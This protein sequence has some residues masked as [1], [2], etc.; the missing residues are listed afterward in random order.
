MGDLLLKQRP[1]TVKHWQSLE[2]LSRRGWP[3]VHPQYL[4][5]NRQILSFKPPDWRERGN[6]ILPHSTYNSSNYCQINKSRDYC[7]LAPYYRNA[8]PPP[9]NPNKDRLLM[10]DPT[11][12]R[13]TSR[14]AEVHPCQCRSR[15][16]DD[17]RP[18]FVEMSS[19][20]EED[21]NG[22]K[23]GRRHKNK[24]NYDKHSKKYRSNRRSM[25]NLLL[26]N[27]DVAQ[28]LQTKSIDLDNSDAS[29]GT[30]PR[31]VAVTTLEDVQAVRCAE[32]HPG[33][34]L[35]AVGSNSKTLRICGYPKLGDVSYTG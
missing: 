15:S 20:W 13:V 27:Y 31:F 24:S 2:M 18:E 10:I 12:R 28:N 7:Y 16:L 25:D 3:P 4:A 19:E 32:F 21:E 22:N 26:D 5:H 9:P 6:Y 8:M 17:V 34:Q 1:P 23:I 11:R 30:R 14:K 35:Y 33:G 29:S